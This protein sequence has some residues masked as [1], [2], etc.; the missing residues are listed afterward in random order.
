MTKLIKMANFV[1]KLMKNLQNELKHITLSAL[2]E[3]IRIAIESYSGGEQW[4]VAEVSSVQVNYSGHCYLELVERV[5]GQQ[6]PCAVCRAVIWGSRYKMLAAYFRDTTGSDLVVGMKVLVRCTAS[7]HAVYGLSLVISDVDPTYTI[8]EVERVRQQTIARLQKEGVWDMN[9]EFALPIVVQRVAVVS[10]ATAAGYGDFCNELARSAFHFDVTLFQSTMQ[11]EGAEKS[12]IEALGAIAE[13]EFDAVIIIRGGGSVSD[14]ACF[15]NYLLC[16]N[17][18]QFPMPIITGIG[19]ERDTSVADMVACKSLKTPTAVAAFLVECAAAFAGRLSAAEQYIVQ[20]AVQTVMNESQRVENIS[21][22]LS[23]IVKQ[24]IH[25]SSL[26]INTLES[27]L[28]FSG[29]AIIKLKVGQCDALIEA[30]TGCAKQKIV[31][32]MTLHQQKKSQIGV[33]AQ[34]MIAAERHRLEMLEMSIEASNPRRILQL[35]YA[36]VN[37]GVHSLSNIELGDE[38]TVEMADGILKAK[39]NEKWQKKS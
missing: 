28:K 18:A 26:K 24:Y 14:L 30:I 31:E 37:G 11:G 19:H 25:N 5:A 21:L 17:I 1:V 35:G 9:R 38:L 27:S 20:R 23:K 3:R 13:E 15:D 2:V 7:Y 16:A 10:S 33:L 32:Q 8:G 12:I 34:G 6:M 36:I 22:Y 4:V 29:A 39:V